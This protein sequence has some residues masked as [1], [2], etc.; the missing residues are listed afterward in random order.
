MPPKSTDK[1]D[2]LESIAARM[3]DANLI[4][5]LNYLKTLAPMPYTAKRIEEIEAYIDSVYLP[6]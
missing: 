3:W 5:Y 4:A 1:G 6:K 2:P